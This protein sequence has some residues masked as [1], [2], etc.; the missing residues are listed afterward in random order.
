MRRIAD[1]P[2]R[3]VAPAGRGT[4]DLYLPED[5]AEADCLVWFHGGGLVEG[6]KGGPQPPMLMPAGWALSCANYRLLQHGP[7]PACIEDA[8]AAL[9]WAPQAL[10]R[11]GVRCRRLAVGGCSAGAYLAAMVALDRSWLAAAGAGDLR[12]HGAFPLSGQMA[13]HFAYRGTIGHPAWRPLVD[14]FAPLW[15]VR[16]DAPPLLLVAAENDMPCRPEENR[17]LVA[18]LRETGHR[19]AECHVIPGRDHGTIGAFMSDPADPV[20]RLMHR[21]LTDLPG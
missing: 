3:A 6:D 1:L 18:A 2:Y 4:A 14:R 12:V 7:F 16:A 8:A 11:A 15:H 13:S 19:A 17:Y 10:A 9:A 21:F 5:A 20:T